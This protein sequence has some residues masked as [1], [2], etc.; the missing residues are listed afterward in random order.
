MLA[1]NSV[2]DKFM[3]LEYALYDL[4]QAAINENNP[5]GLQ[6]IHPDY[7]NALI[8]NGFIVNK[9]KDEYAEVREI[10]I[11]TDQDESFFNIIINPTMNCNFKCWYCYENHIKS[12]KMSEDIIK[13][14]YKLIDNVTSKEKTKNLYLSWFGGEPLL[15]FDK[16]MIPILEYA[17]RKTIEKNIGFESDITTNGYLINQKMI[18]NFIQYNITHN[19]IT[20]DGHRDLHN[21]VRNVNEKR[22]SY[23]EIINNVKLLCKNNI[24][25]TLRINFTDET[26][27]SVLNIIEDISDI[28]NDD[29]EWL[30]ISFHQVWQTKEKGNLELSEKLKTIKKTFKENNFFVSGNTRDNIRNSCYAD[31]TNEVVIN[32]NGDAFKCTARDFTKNNRE[33]ILQEDGTIDW[34]E[35]NTTRLM[36]KL[37]N[38]PCQTCPILPLCG[39][40]CSQVAFEN[41]GEDYCVYDFDIEKKKE[42]VRE[43]II[44]CMNL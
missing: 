12:S 44:E 33:G 2:N 36:A 8:Q 17:N 42:V 43:H 3:L 19:Q 21:T 22:G 23:D 1:Y 40:G 35:K 41:N 28:S 10:I 38:K 4:L 39:S 6:E 31:K 29:R 9:E 26:L 18:N 7:F 20:L 13:K 30:E 37:N 14:V 11:N 27:K 24:S 5:I 32:Y 15:Y 34:F 25:T 16:V